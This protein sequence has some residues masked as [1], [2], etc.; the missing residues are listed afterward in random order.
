MFAHEAANTRFAEAVVHDSAGGFSGEAPAPVRFADPVTEFRV[1]V[2]LGRETTNADQFCVVFDAEYLFVL[3]N[4]VD[5]LQR[6]DIGLGVRNA[7]G[8]ARDIPIARKHCDAGGVAV[9][10][11]SEAK[12]SGLHD[13]QLREQVWRKVM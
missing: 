6:G 12:A 3:F 10:D 1:A 13:G 11:G 9:D 2:R 7:S 8:H 4:A 5:P